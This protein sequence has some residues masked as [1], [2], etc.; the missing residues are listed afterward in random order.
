MSGATQHKKTC[1]LNLKLREVVIFVESK[2]FFA[3]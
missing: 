1:W 2:G 3:E